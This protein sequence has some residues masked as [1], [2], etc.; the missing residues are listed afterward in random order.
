M[1]DDDYYEN[2]GW[3]VGQICENGHVINSRAKTSPQ[4]NQKRCSQCGKPTLSACPACGATIRG[5]YH[6]P[7]VTDLTRMVAP[8]YCHECGQPYPWTAERLATARA[9]VAEAEGL[10]AASKGVFND[11]VQDLVGEQP[12]TALAAQRVN[13]VLARL[14]KPVAATVR[15]LLVDIASETAKKIIVG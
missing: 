14:G 3:D 11:N 12:R 5:K 1:W 6:H 2:E 7:R 15:G 9:I 4:Y 8:A 13:R 10:D